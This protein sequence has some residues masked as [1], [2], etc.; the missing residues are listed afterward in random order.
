MM[1]APVRSSRRGV[2]LIEGLM[3]TMILLTGMVGVLQGLAVASVQ[4]S[5]ANRHT[6]ASVIAQQLISAIE[7]QG[8]ARLLG[9]GGIFASTNCVSSPGAAAAFQGD[10]VTTPASFASMGWATVTTCYVDYDARGA[11]VPALLALTP[12]YTQQ[13]NDTYTR[14]V[15]VYQTSNPEVMYVGVN[16][17]WRDAGRVRIVKRFTAIYDTATNQTTL[18]Y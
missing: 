9:T 6:R 5:M 4:N 13:D 8:R 2:T 12:G 16:V 7:H 1:R 14:L 10:L 17:G 11:V 3:S 18:E 15:A